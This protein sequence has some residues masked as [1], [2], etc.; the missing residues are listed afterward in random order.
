MAS[1]NEKIITVSNKNISKLLECDIGDEVVVKTSS[2]NNPIRLKVVNVD[3][4]DPPCEDKSHKRAMKRLS[5]VQ[6]RYESKNPFNSKYGLYVYKS[7]GYYQVRKSIHGDYRLFGVYD[8][9][10]HAYFIRDFLMENEWD[11]N[12]LGDIEFNEGMQKYYVIKVIDRVFVLGEFDT[13]EEAEDNIYECYKDFLANI[14]K[15]KN[16]IETHEDL[17]FLIWQFDQL[18][19]EFDQTV[20]DDEFWLIDRLPKLEQSPKPK[21]S[22]YSFDSLYGLTPWQKTMRDEIRKLEKDIFTF[23]ELKDSL[24]RYKTKNFDM[25]VRKH[26]NELVDLG[27]VKA[28]GNDVY[29]KS[30]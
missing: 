22:K 14:F 6:I 20:K 10:D 7:N 18:Y 2:G 12:R 4:F 29:E 15:H 26:L 16:G 30:W 9:L 27:L 1:D 21:K 8:N 28:L 5:P 25:K 11:T 19:L 17:N 13:F 3:Y 23:D 24:S